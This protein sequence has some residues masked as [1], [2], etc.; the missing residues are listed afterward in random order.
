M[1]VRRGATPGSMDTGE[2]PTGKTTR[3]TLRCERSKSG[4]RTNESLPVGVYTL[5]IPFNSARAG[6]VWRQATLGRLKPGNTNPGPSKKKGPR[7]YQA[8]RSERL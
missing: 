3:T 1:K 8:A 6:G 7:P 2:A 4:R 5:K